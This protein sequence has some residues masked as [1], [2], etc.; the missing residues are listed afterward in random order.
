MCR[1]RR[2]LILRAG[3]DAQHRYDDPSLIFMDAEH[4]NEFDFPIRHRLFC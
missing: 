4:R 3:P 2:R 1:G